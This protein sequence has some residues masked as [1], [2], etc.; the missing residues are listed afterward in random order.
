TSYVGAFGGS[1]WLKGWT[2]L[3]QLGYVAGEG[4]VAV[5][6]SSGKPERYELSRN[7]PNPFNP[8]TM[9][10]YAVPE[11]G[12]VTL[13]V[14]NMLG[15]EVTTLVNEVQEAG[16]YQ[17]TWDAAQCNSGMYFV[18]MNAGGQVLTHKMMFLK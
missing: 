11:R 12:L 15:Q 5:Q 10:Q 1:N 4:T 8:S 13:T 14:F 17:M 16:V 2:A 18:R 9:V 3:D 6:I 7:Y